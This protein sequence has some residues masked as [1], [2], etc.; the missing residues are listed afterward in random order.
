MCPPQNKNHARMS[1]THDV[2][3]PADPDRINS[4]EKQMNGDVWAM[5]ELRTG[6]ARV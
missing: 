4:S 3:V 5:E 6:E 1:C 2:D